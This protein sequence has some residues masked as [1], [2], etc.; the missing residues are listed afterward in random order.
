MPIIHILTKFYSRDKS[1][2][3]I[4]QNCFFQCYQKFLASLESGIKTAP[5]TRPTPLLH[6]IGVSDGITE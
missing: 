5:H 2:S 3:E 6:G 1:V 4:F